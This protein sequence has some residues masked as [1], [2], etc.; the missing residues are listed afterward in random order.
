MTLDDQVRAVIRDELGLS[1]D[2]PIESAT[3]LY[4]LGADSLDHVQVLIGLEKHFNINIDV[5][6]LNTRPMKDHTLGWLTQLVEEK[7]V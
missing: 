7:L 2:L 1:P 3:A 5:G 6:V 4:S